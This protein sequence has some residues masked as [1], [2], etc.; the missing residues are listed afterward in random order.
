MKIEDAEE[1]TQSLGQIVAGGW[2][3]IALGERLGVP[4]AL[5]LETKDWVEQRLGGYVK[6]SIEERHGA[7]KEL[8]DEG[9]SVRKIGEITGV[10]HQTVAND[11]KK[12]TPEPVDAIAALAVGA[13]KDKQAKRR[14]REDALRAKR[15]E[16]EDAARQAIAA[17]DSPFDLHIGDLRDWRPVCDSI[18]TDPPYVGDSIPLYEALR[19][20]A[21]DVLPDGAPLVVMTWQAILPD[22]MLALQHPDLA[23]RWTICWRYDNNEN[24][25]DY[26][27]RVFDC[28]KPILVYHKGVMADDAPMIRD[29]IA[30]AMPDKD[31]H[32]W[33]QSLEG[34]ERLVRSFSEPGQIICDPF[35]G[36]GT[37]AL[38]ALSQA[39]QFVGCDV[40]EAA[41]RKSEARLV[42]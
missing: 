32:E 21:V 2:R 4:K 5:G 1:Y 3:Q 31:H 33:G 9:L 27:R 19:D 40:D 16:Q 15:Q 30:S 25:S 35:L 13:A 17:S 12:L 41:V 14:E 24:T 37:T 22:V 38:A 34:F 26:A 23:Y 11:V 29:E 7:V 10:S 28:W 8:T 6:L 39:R 20:F 18:I 42:A 36:A